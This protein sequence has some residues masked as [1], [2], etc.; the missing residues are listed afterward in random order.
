[1]KSTCK[2]P[3]GCDRLVKARG[4]CKVHSER[5]ARTGDAGPATIRSPRKLGRPCAIDDC[6]GIVDKT[7]GYDMCGKHYQRFA[8]H[9]DPS[10]VAIGGASLRL[11]QNPR[12]S[13]DDASYNAVH[14]R[15]REQRGKASGYQCSD[16]GKRARE[17]S[18]DCT[19]AHEKVD[20][21]MGRYSTDMD[22]YVPRCVSCHRL[23]DRKQAL[24]TGERPD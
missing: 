15:L 11:E 4:W 9:G 23:F 21:A 8:K 20:T 12:W 16:C 18:Y 10:V 22:R 5:I 14:I 1:M 2:H 6:G 19:D 13:G 24:L 3:D 7:G 17:W